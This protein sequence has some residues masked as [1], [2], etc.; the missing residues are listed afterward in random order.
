MD[1]AFST[2]KE[3]D[4]T[5][6]CAWAVTPTADMLLLDMVRTRTDSP[7]VIMDM[8]GDIVRKYRLDYLGIEKVQGQALVVRAAMDAGL[9]IRPLIPDQDKITRSIPAQVRMENGQVYLPAGH[10]DLEAIEAELLTFPKAAHDDIVDCF[11][12]AA[13]EVQRFGG[14]PEPDDVREARERAE[15]ETRGTLEDDALWS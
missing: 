10:P 3:A 11:A 12:Y 13:A 4:Y 9:T 14:A 8:A 5:V 6:T 2:K 7:K 15:A 1:L